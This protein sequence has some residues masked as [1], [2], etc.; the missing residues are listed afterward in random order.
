MSVRRTTPYLV[1][2]MVGSVLSA[3]AGVLAIWN[4]T[5]STILLDI[6][7]AMFLILLVLWVVEDSKAHSSIYK[8]FDYD[9]LLYLFAIPYLPYYLWRTRK[10]KRVVLLGGFVALYL[11]GYLAQLVCYAV[12]ISAESESP[13]V[14]G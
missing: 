3:V 12:V 14:T 5:E 1:G 2:L 7:P 4:G 6:W 8:P 10:M 9:F 11:L 13:V